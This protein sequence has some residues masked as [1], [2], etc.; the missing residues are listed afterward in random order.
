MY[1]VL[2][3]LLRKVQKT[4]VRK[5]YVE[6]AIE[7]ANYQLALSFD[8]SMD[9][10]RDQLKDIEKDGFELGCAQGRLRLY[11]ESVTIDGY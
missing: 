6:E 1:V 8:R 7:E 2:F 3:V 10:L 5:Q 9:I 11:V 4:F